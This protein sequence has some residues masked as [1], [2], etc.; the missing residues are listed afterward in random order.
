MEILK[1]TLAQLI[2]SNINRFL[3]I[4]IIALMYRI[5]E[6]TEIGE[7]FFLISIFSIFVTIREFG[8]G[9]IIIKSYMN[10]DEEF[11]EIFRT[12]IFLSLILIVIFFLIAFNIDGAINSSNIYF[13]SFALGLSALTLNFILEAKQKYYYL[14]I[15]QFLSQFILFLVF[16]F[17][18]I[19]NKNLLIS[20]HQA[21]PSIILF[22]GVSYY[23]Y[24][25]SLF[26]ATDF[27]KINTNIFISSSY[28]FKHRVLIFTQLFL[29]SIMFFDYIIAKT[30]LNSYD[31][32]IF[33]GLL[34]LGA[35]TFG[36]LI[37]VN[38]VMY[39]YALDD[40][41]TFLKNKKHILK[42][43]SFITNIGLLLLI[44]PY[45]K[46]VMNINEPSIY[47]TSSFLI[48]I[49][50]F[51]IPKFFDVIN[52]IEINSE[53]FSLKYILYRLF[54][55]LALIVATIVVLTEIVVIFKIL[56][57]VAFIFFI[58]WFLVTYALKGLINGYKAK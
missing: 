25:N 47:F 56:D 57:V 41:E 28:F 37:V 39:T 5:F 42:I 33:T 34:R 35:A 23:I 7:Y 53:Q 13:I 36:I 52:H 6:I 32:G 18:Y 30:F 2:S 15:I 49:G 44:Y 26:R 20:Y 43:V 48:L 58:K 38:K 27:L 17:A 54:L 29:A 19:T 40:K 16:F 24:R 9:K 8:S 11:L 51:L 21:L 12:R 22:L 10:R 50:S 55:V 45:I 3:G 46:F 4:A 31:L 1:S 14:S